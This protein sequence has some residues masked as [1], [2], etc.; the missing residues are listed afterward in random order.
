MGLLFRA[1]EA[2]GPNRPE[3]SITPGLFMFRRSAPVCFDDATPAVW[4]RGRTSPV[5]ALIRSKGIAC[6]FAQ[7]SF[8]PTTCPEC[9]PWAPLAT[10]GCPARLR[11]LPTYTRREPEGRLKKNR[12]GPEYR[13]GP[14]NHA[15]AR[16]SRRCLGQHRRGRGARLHAARGGRGPAGS[17]AHES[18][19]P[20]A[21]GGRKMGANSRPRPERAAVV[22]QDPALGQVHPHPSTASFPAIRKPEPPSRGHADK[23]APRRAATCPDL[24]RRCPRSAGPPWQPIIAARRPRARPPTRPHCRTGFRLATT[25]CWHRAGPPWSHGV[26]VDAQVPL[27]AHVL[28]TSLVT[29]IPPARACLGQYHGR[30]APTP[31]HHSPTPQ[32]RR[33]H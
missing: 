31:S 11:R 15:A 1:V 20:A 17:I 21:T 27:P 32:R 4:Q 6:I 7:S 19:A 23:P 13:S 22:A 3:T 18:S 24:A 2:A 30:K 28:A 25:C 5:V 8:A 14:A 26:R 16:L 12:R 9:D 33:R 29:V 10:A